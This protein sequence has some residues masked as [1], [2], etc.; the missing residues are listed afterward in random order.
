MGKVEKSKADVVSDDV[1]KIPTVMMTSCNFRRVKFVG[2]R[3]F[4]KNSQIFS[5][6]PVFHYVR[7]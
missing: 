4:A 7:N 6:L 2:V 3:C 5:I 1:F